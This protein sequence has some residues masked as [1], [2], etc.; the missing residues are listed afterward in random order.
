MNNAKYI[1][2][3]NAK[4]RIINTTIKRWWYLHDI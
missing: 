1:K 3:Q 4:E 2:L